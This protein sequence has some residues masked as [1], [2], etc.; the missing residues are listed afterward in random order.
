MI[1]TTEEQREILRNFYRNM[2]PQE[3]FDTE[4]YA[5]QAEYIGANGIFLWQSKSLGWETIRGDMP[6]NPSMR[7]ASGNC[8]MGDVVFMRMP[9]D[10]YNMLQG[11][12]KAIV[13]EQRGELTQEE[14]R[15]E[16]DEK[17]S[18]LLGHDINIS[19]KFRDQ[20]DPEL[21]K[22]RE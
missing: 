5:Y 1:S 10:R 2:T 6:E 20:R 16:I 17:V 19:F 13:R 8:T 3:N 7:D 12:R 21:T 14:V 4:K 11:A 9:L 22:R 15:R 18:R